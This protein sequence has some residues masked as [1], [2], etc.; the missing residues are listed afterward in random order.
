[1][2]ICPCKPLR[3]QK[4][5]NWPFLMV[6]TNSL[7]CCIKKDM[8]AG[9]C[10]EKDGFC[11]L[12]MQAG[13]AEWQRLHYGR[14]PNWKIGHSQSQRSAGP[15]LKWTA[16]KYT[17]QHFFFGYNN[18]NTNTNVNHEEKD[19]KQHTNTKQLLTTG[20]FINFYFLASR[21]IFRS[22]SSGHFRRKR[23]SGGEGTF[24]HV[25]RWQ[26]QYQDNLIHFNMQTETIF[27]WVAFT[28]KMFSS[29]YSHY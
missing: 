4:V 2:A 29:I 10:N 11:G 23:R 9:C 28:P 17:K 24:R 19:R 25:W 12:G 21:T 26:A 18:K 6:L 1:M 3:G 14:P 15:A 5:S 8:W 27:S 7:S 16:H 22:N 13:G 20:R